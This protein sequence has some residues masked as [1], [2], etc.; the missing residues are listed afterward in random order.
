[1]AG[2]FRPEVMDALI[3][4]FG[5]EDEE[6]VLER[7]GIDIREV[8]MAQSTEFV[9]RATFT[10]KMPKF[11]RLIAHD[12]GTFETEW[13]VRIKFDGDGRYYGYVS[14]PLADE[15]KLS[16]Y[17]FPDLTAPGRFEE[18]QKLT[19]KYKK[20]YFVK[21]LG[22]ATIH[23]QAW[24]L[25]GFQQWL[26]DLLL[27]DTFVEKLSDQILEFDLELIKR[28]AQMGV[29]IISIGGDIAVSN[30]LVMPPDIWRKF[31]KYREAKLIEE[32]KK[33]G[34]KHFFYHSDGNILPVLADLVEIGFTIF[35]PIQPECMDPQE[36]KRKFG[37]RITLHGTISAQ[38][39][40]PFGTVQDV[41]AEI[42]QRITTLGRRGGLILAPLTVQPD[43]PLEN[44]IAVYDTARQTPLPRE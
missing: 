17:K 30:N 42:R 31:F 1:L 7:F 4:H 37:D 27:N 44:I 35:D 25:R 8:R 6:G 41:E 5:V 11:K 34:I 23:R 21:A 16:T 20:D 32:G 2:D 15:S 40:M 19:Q 14:C 26:E 29:D 24:E 3:K 33:W 43:V 39:T 18:A 9:E 13:G 38:Q 22:L 10:H 12:D 28:L 36:V